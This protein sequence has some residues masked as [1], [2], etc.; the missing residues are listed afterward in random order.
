[1]F[2]AINDGID[3]GGRTMASHFGITISIRPDGLGGLQA[4]RYEYQVLGMLHGL[5]CTQTGRAVLRAI[6]FYGRYVLIYPY[7]GRLGKNNAATY[8]DWGMY[9]AKV[10]FNPFT[11]PHSYWK[12]P[13]ASPHEVLIHELGHAVRVVSKTFFHGYQDDVD[14]S[15][16]QEAR[17]KEEGIAML[18]ANIFSSETHRC[19]RMGYDNPM[20]RGPE[21]KF[22]PADTLGCGNDLERYFDYAVD[23]LLN[24]N[25]EFARSL[26]Q[27]NTPF[28]PIRDAPKRDK[29]R[30]ED[31]IQDNN[32]MQQ[33][34]PH[35]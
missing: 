16:Y 29:E 20:D 32:V 9:R 24:E 3:L 25:P 12:W 28:N 7:D 8:S 22:D 11:Y 35:N 1:L 30:I 26:A 13:G 10:S 15:T 18:V 19:L 6:Q 34:F 27:V 31:M 14:D 2:K 23:D 33:L 21:E 17:R 4:D 5:N